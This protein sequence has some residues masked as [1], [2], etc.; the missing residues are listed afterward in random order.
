MGWKPEDDWV[1]G[2]KSAR[3]VK[4]E[5]DSLGRMVEAQDEEE[6]SA[7]ITEVAK[8]VD[9]I[10][11]SG[12]FSVANPWHEEHAA[13]LARQLTHLPVVTGHT[14]TGE[15]GIKERTITAVL[16][17][18]LLPVIEE[19]LTAVKSA[20]TAMNIKARILV[21]KG[22][23]GLMSLEMARERPVETI[24]SGPAA[25]LMG[26]KALSQLDDCI[27]VDVGGTSTDIAFLEGGFPRLDME[28]AI[29]GDWRTRV[30]AIDM[31]TCGLG[32]DS[33]VS[34]SEDGDLLIGPQR[35]VPLA[36]ASTMRDD[37]KR[38]LLA[39]QDT[40]FYVIGKSDLTNLNASERK[41]HSFIAA[42]GPSSL[43][44]TMDGVKDVVLVNDCIRSLMKRGNLLR[45]G[46]TPTDLMHLSG[47]YSRGDAEASRIGLQILAQKMD[48]DPETLAARIMTRV[49][50]RIGEEIVKKAMA[51]SVG[52]MPSSKQIDS[53]LHATVGEKSFP[54]LS[55]RAALDR[56]IVGIGA[57]AS[58]LIG[59][60]AKRMDAQVVIPE[61]Y[62]VGNAVGAVL[63]EMTESTSIEISPVGDK[64]MLFW[65]FSAPLQFSH[66]EEAVSSARTQVER[67]VTERL[68]I[69][70][71]SDI[72]VKV[73]RVDVRFNDGYGKEMKFVNAVFVKATGT[74]KPSLDDS[75]AR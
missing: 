15:L 7:A 69:A 32:G 52:P 28:G 35:V 45:T 4:G 22:D 38:R 14:L 64:F 51:D 13:E 6:L 2:C 16:N 59:P 23:G 57:P 3:F 10:V 34:L 5:F 65:Q 39:A 1:L 53:M 18:K 63:S 67:H 31:W 26:G 17:A 55:L 9:A 61:N 25:S 33:L 56:P 47:E 46:L 42:N 12:M 44:E 29:V 37:F 50:T 60:L 40:T 72:K 68:T 75:P 73:E 62:D 21:F 49:V 8:E 54:R 24:L 58:I 36:V 27:V 30:K 74:G 41:V 20:L 48:A 70:R 43:Y 19:F 71:A 11:I 66:L